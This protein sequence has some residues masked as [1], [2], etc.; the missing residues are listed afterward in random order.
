[1]LPGEQVAVE[2]EAGT[3]RLDDLQREEPGPQRL[4][5][6]G[7]VAASFR[8]E[9]HDAEVV[10]LEHDA[11]GGVHR[12]QHALHRAGVAVVGRLLAVVREA[13]GDPPAVLHRVPVVSGGPRVDLDLLEVGDAPAAHGLLPF[14]T[15]AKG[16]DGPVGVVEQQR[17]ADPVTRCPL[18][19][20]PG[21]QGDHHLHHRGVRSGQ[22]DQADP[23]V[24]RVPRLVGRHQGPTRFVQ[25][26]HGEQH[27]VVDPTALPHHGHGGPD[28]VGGQGVERVGGGRWPVNH[29]RSPRHDDGPTTPRRH[30]APPQAPPQ[31]PSQHPW[32][33]LRSPNRA[34]PRAPSGASGIGGSSLGDDDRTYRGSG[35][36]GDGPC[37]E[38][39]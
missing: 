11:P 33:L 26:H 15:L 18:H 2:G 32:S 16:Q 5:V 27:A 3:V 35:A 10:D 23:P 36:G 28:L 39:S 1:M 22:D 21:G 12:G 37:R 30:R 24:D 4:V 25:G 38:G 14:R 20:L 29:A 7:E 8:R 6:L 9:R 17:R 31:A 19:D 13:P 34:P